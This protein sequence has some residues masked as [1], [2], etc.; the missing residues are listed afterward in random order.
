MR[1]L[2]NIPFC[3][4]GLDPESS[5]GMKIIDSGLRR[6]DDRKTEMEFFKVLEIV[7]GSQ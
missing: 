7:A 6:N 5:C 4:S 3:H 2:K 1:A